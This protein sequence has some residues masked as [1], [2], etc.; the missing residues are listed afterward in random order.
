MIDTIVLWSLLISTAALWLYSMCMTRELRRQDLK[1]QDLQRQQKQK[2][3]VE[4]RCYCCQMRDDC[5]A[6]ELDVLYPC[7]YF[8]ED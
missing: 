8:E 1:I 2:Q 4:D 5:P 7:P 6:F 3:L